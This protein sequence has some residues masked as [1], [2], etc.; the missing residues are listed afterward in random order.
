MKIICKSK[1]SK[2]KFYTLFL[3]FFALLLL[4]SCAT[5]QWY[6]AESECSIV[7]QQYYP[8][9]YQRMLVTKTYWVDVL[10]GYECLKTHRSERCHVRTIRIPQYYQ[11]W[12]DV[13]INV[14]ARN[15]YIGFCTQEVCKQ[16]YGN[17][18]CKVQK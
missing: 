12:E 10:D 1:K 7:G 18:D 15:R 11:A 13:D 4:P 3:Y 2:S 9:N 5:E 16:R 17:V 8:P 6:Q 14:E